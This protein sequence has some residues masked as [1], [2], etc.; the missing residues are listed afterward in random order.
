MILSKKVESC[1]GVMV[2]NQRMVNKFQQKVKGEKIKCF[3]LFVVKNL[4]IKK[5][6]F[7]YQ[8][9]QNVKVKSML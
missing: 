4:A 7:N 2:V 3:N 5:F 9:T 8:D 1:Y 6:I